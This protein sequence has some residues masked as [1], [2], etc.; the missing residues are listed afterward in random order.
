MNKVFY[1]V[2][3]RLSIIATSLC[4]LS[5]NEIFLVAKKLSTSVDKIKK[6]VPC[7]QQLKYAKSLVEAYKKKCL[8]K[9]SFQLTSLSEVLLLHPEIE[10]IKYG[11]VQPFEYKPFPIS[12]FSEL[13]PNKGFFAERFILRIP[14][15]QV[16]SSVG[17][18]KVDN[19]IIEDL[20][21]PY[22]SRCAKIDWVKSVASFKDKKKIKGKVAV[23]TSA[24]ESCYAHW[25]CQILGRLAFIEMHN[26]N[27]DY[28]YI[29]KSLRPFMKQ[30]LELWGIDNSKIIEPYRDT[31]YIE[32]DELIVP[33]QIGRRAPLADEFIASYIPLERYAKKW[34][35]SLDLLVLKNN[36]YDE[37]DEIPQDVP[38]EKIFCHYSEL[39]LY[40]P[41]DIINY[42]KNKFI[43][44]INDKNFAFS[45]KI[46]I[47]RK[48]T[49]ARRASNEDEVFELFKAIGFERYFM[50]NLSYLEQVAL[51]RNAEI[52]A[53][54]HGSGMMNIMYCQPKAKVIE[55][56]QA[57]SECGFYYL[58]QSLGLD[59]ECVKSVDF[60]E[61]ISGQIDVPFNID[62]IKDFIQTYLR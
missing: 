22:F 28:L 2:L 48:N 4:A 12:I 50:E 54:A 31:Q 29:P 3:L 61:N 10:Y 41:L 13:Q 16:A 11:N 51:F 43:P 15:G 27:Y 14:Q 47:S 59:Y 57:R 60:N 9:N 20:I 25:I 32:A 34:N 39:C 49:S 23:V 7:W 21:A 30:M 8:K 6:T 53:G 38:T 45:K 55:L 58:S 40:Y 19:M 33:C 17:Y 37:Q 26:I 24:F 1:R 42:I 35:M 44:L 62:K 5:E 36:Y 56:Y 46:F 52:I 18:I